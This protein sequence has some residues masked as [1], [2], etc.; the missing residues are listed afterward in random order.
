MIHIIDYQKLNGYVNGSIPQPSATLIT[1]DTASPNYAYASWI[2]A[3]QHAL[4]LIQSLLFEE[5]ITRTLGHTT[6]HEVW[7]AL[8]NTYQHDSL[9]LT[10]TLRDSI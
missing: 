9:E 4:I 3:D 1:G 7:N 5:A 6:S 8:S 2:A 10:R